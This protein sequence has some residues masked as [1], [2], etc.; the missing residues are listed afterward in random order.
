MFNSNFQ[1]QNAHPIIRS[2]FH[3]EVD[4]GTN[5]EGGREPLPPPTLAREAR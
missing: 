3:G 4:L 1:R 2:Y 5:S